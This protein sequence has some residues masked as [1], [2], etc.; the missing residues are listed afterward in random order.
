[1]KSSFSSI[2]DEIEGVGEKRKN[3]L[4]KHFQSLKKMKEASAK[5][6][7]A[8]GLPKRIAKVVEETLAS[9]ESNNL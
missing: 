9:Y 2:L 1:L 8:A 7:Q 5:D 6:L 4:L 3:A